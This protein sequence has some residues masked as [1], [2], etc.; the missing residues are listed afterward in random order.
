MRIMDSRAGDTYRFCRMC[1]IVRDIP[2]D[3]GEY[4]DRLYAAL[5][6]D[7][8][9]DEELIR[10]RL[11][12]CEGCDRNS[13]GTCLACGCYCLIRSFARSQRCPKKKW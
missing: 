10:S 1:D 13:L 5:D 6:E 2:S 8:R 7:E 9:A 11:S 3:I 4:A 12:V